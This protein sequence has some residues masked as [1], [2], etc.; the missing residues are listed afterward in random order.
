MLAAVRAQPGCLQYDTALAKIIRRRRDL[1]E[2][3]QGA[4]FIS[5]P[6]ANP[7]TMPASPAGG[8]DHLGWLASVG[9]HL[10]LD[11]LVKKTSKGCGRG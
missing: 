1:A 5:A 3:G 9:Q 2:I 4:W 7:A 6:I 8:V 11:V 10:V